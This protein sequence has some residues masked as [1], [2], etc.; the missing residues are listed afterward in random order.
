MYKTLILV[1]AISSSALGAEYHVAV[2]GDDT[3]AGSKSKPFKTISAAANIAQPGDTITVHAGTYRERVTPP[4]G[5][6][7]D[8]KRITYQ[9]APG[10]KVTITGSDVFKVWE[11]VGGDTW[12][13]TIPNSY[14]GN[15]N[16]YAE[17]V[18]GDW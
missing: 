8:T 1:A 3:N 9:A 11:K 2:T 5:G 15:F 16:P 6:T 14:F 4:R 12:K 17:K 13:L 10:E 18:H 7:S